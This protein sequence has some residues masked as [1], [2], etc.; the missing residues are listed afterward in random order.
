ME[1]E[2]DETK[3]QSN[4]EIHGLDFADA[5]DFEWNSVLVLEDNRRDYQETRYIAYGKL[6]GRLTVLVFA[7]R[8][9][10]I[11]VISFRRA[12]SREVS[13]YESQIEN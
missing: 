2:W 9:E 4:L 5:F 11:R 3:R 10:A 13:R 8:D 1:Y 6:R 12:N 7:L